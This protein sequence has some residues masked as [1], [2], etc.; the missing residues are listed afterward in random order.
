MTGEAMMKN[1]LIYISVS[2]FLISCGAKDEYPGMEFAPNMYHSVPYEPLSQITDSDEGAWVNS[3]EDDR[4]EYYNSNIYN[5][6]NMTMRVPPANTIKRNIGYK[7]PYR[8]PK[9]TIGSTYYL[10]SAA[11]TLT[12]PLDSTEAIVQEGQSLYLVWCAH[13]HGGSGKGDGA[14]GQR[15]LG[16]PNYS[17]GRYKTLTGGHIFHVITHGLNRMGPHASQIDVLDRWK[18]VKYVQ[19]LQQQGS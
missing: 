12:N 6:F 5:P 1:L 16:I 4:G 7:L 11:R 15:Y 8:I 18:I 13:C 19:V 14:V 2:I 17:V 3:L 10:D 9:D